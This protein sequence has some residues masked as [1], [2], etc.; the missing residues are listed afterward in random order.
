MLYKHK[1]HQEKTSG[2]MQFV[3]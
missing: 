1:N 3:G 2:S